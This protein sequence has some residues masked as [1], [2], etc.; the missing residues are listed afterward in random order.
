M[1]KKKAPTLSTLLQSPLCLCCESFFSFMCSYVPSSFSVTSSPQHRLKTLEICYLSTAVHLNLKTESELQ[2]E[3]DPC[4]YTDH[5]RIWL[6]TFRLFLRLF[7][8]IF[9]PLFLPF[10]CLITEVLPGVQRSSSSC[11]SFPINLCSTKL[12]SDISSWR[13]TIVSGR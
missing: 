5:H 10:L 9:V 4:W 6:E 11:S 7:V 2:L 13:Q 1:K 12:V 3:G 8:S